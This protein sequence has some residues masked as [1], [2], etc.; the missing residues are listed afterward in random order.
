MVNLQVETTELQ[1]LRR[2]KKDILSVINSVQVGR[3]IAYNEESNT[4]DVELLVRRSVDVTQSV[5]EYPPLVDLPLL[6]QGASD[7]DLT[8][9]DP[10][11]SDCLVIFADRSI[12]EWFETGQAYT[13]KNKRMHDLSDGFV[14]L[15]PRHKGDP[16]QDYD[17]EATMLKKGSS[18]II[19]KDDE[20]VL[21]NG[22]VSI[23]LLDDMIVLDGKVVI[24]DNLE[25]VGNITSVG[26]L[27]VNGLVD[28]ISTV[29]A[30]NFIK[31]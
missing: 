6:W 19:L 21:T 17:K 20:A 13:P 2:L 15:R 28:V 16:L 18:K 10:T 31:R 7:G 24:G 26:D 27:F 4:V 8:F 11:G 22:K 14:L 9:P 30:S 1:R 5:T 25:V 29:T 3:I 12:D 23:K